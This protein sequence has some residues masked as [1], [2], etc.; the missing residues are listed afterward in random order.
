MLGVYEQWVRY[1]LAGGRQV[2]P[3]DLQRWYDGRAALETHCIVSTVVRLI[4]TEMLDLSQ[5]AI[6]LRM[7][8]SESCPSARASRSPGSSRSRSAAKS[9]P[10]SVMRSTSFAETR[11]R[12]RS[13]CGTALY[14]RLTRHQPRGS[15]VAV[16]PEE[17]GEQ[18]EENE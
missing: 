11:L 2:L 16:S 13:R 1:G 17:E 15:P 6:D 5:M 18:E 14:T 4:Y 12:L 8:G 3:P 9:T 7:F 10:H